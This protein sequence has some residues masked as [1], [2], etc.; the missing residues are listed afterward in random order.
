[1]CVVF[2]LLKS[3]L[4]ICL[5]Q[6]YTATPSPWL[7]FI[8]IDLTF[9][10]LQ[11]FRGLYVVHYGKRAFTRV[12]VPPISEQKRGIKSFSFGYFSSETNRQNSSLS[13]LYE[14]ASLQIA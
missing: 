5:L 2:L 13:F 1:M 11:S 6:R 3:T 4:F 12:H 7:L 14:A 8:Q 9:I 10:S